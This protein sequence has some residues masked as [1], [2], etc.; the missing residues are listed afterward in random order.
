MG[1]AENGLP[2][3]GLA[4]LPRPA[5]ERRAVPPS[6]EAPEAGKSKAGA[7]GLPRRG[8]EALEA[9]KEAPRGQDSGMFA[10]KADPEY[11]LKG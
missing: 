6:P 3:A 9:A 4:D 5:E 1:S 2:A 8:E 7:Q 11:R 10:L